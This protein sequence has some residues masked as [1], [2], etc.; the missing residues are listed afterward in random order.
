MELL[1]T[2]IINNLDKDE[3]LKERK[4]LEDDY[5]HEKRKEA[6]EYSNKKIQ[7]ANE[8]FYQKIKESNDYLF[9]RIKEA[10]EYTTNLI[11]KVDAYTYEKKLELE[12]YSRK[13]NNNS[14]F[15]VDIY[16]AEKKRAR[17]EVKQEVL[18]FFQKQKELFM[19]KLEINK[20]NPNNLEKLE[21]EGLGDE[22]SS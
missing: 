10:N 15:N 6:E 20:V 9:K 14:N 19:K 22:S 21:K 5:S 4:V 7:E 18:A 16:E 11:K 12:E 13:V 2:A 1:Q 8:Y 3:T 17:M